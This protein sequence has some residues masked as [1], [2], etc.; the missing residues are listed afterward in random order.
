MIKITNIGNSNLF[1]FEKYLPGKLSPEQGALGVILDGSAA[2]A[3][4]FSAEDGISILHHLFIGTEY[5]RKGC[6]AALLSAAREAY[7]PFGIRDMICYFHEE[8][9]MKELLE[10]TGFVCVPGPEFYC[11]RV[12]PI[13]YPE[14]KLHRKN[15]KERI[16]SF[17]QV[18]RAQ[19]KAAAR[20]LPENGVDPVLLSEGHY[21]PTVSFAV[22]NDE[23]ISGMILAHQEG[24]HFYVS[25]LLTS[26]DSFA[27]VPLLMK[28][29]DRLL[30]RSSKES[31]VFFVAN[32]DSVIRFLKNALPEEAKL[33][34][35]SQI[36]SGMWSF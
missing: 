23:K 10:K 12:T 9:G 24:I 36:I 35:E 16:V 7:V 30:E 22:L 5:R 20:L 26:D 13:T 34:K 15:E 11:F 2:G 21:D 31:R 4:V 18:T 14:N 8:K 6:A 27:F 17:D 25:L 33:K 3:A 1:A 19:K 29:F 28:F 32:T